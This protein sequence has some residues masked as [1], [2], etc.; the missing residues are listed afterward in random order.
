MKGKTVLELGSGP[1][2]VGISAAILG[3][4]EVILSD[5]AYTLPLV[6]NNIH[7]NQNAI[8]D[9][10]C[11]SI[12]CMEIDWFKPPSIEVLSSCWSLSLL[13]SGNLDGSTTSMDINSNS[14][15]HMHNNSFPQVVL[16]ADCIWLEGLVNPLMNT[17]EQL[18]H[19]DHTE[20]I[21]TYQRRGKAAH[22]VFWKRLRDAFT[23]IE[24]LDTMAMCGLEKPE[25]ISLLI[26]HR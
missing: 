23:S 9:G 12:K 20:V 17:V 11:N 5:L 2:V 18:S 21:I 8:N 7:L 1:A 6:Q 19:A 16:I 22:D 26:C 24:E 15:T 14:N 13:S 4:K 25:S 3:A 10:E